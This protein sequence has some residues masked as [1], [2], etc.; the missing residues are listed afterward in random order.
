MLENDDSIIFI[1]EEDPKPDQ[2]KVDAVIKEVLELAKSY[3]F[4]NSEEIQKSIIK[5]KKLLKNESKSIF[6]K[7]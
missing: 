3:K 7:R 5:E 6:F 2:D 4:R 1:D